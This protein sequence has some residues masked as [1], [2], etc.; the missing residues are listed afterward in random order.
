MSQNTLGTA[1]VVIVDGGE[2]LGL[3]AGIEA[4]FLSDLRKKR[5]LAIVARFETRQ[6]PA[7]ALD[8][9]KSDDDPLTER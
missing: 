4:E 7:L 2:L 3:L 6:D 1:L 9:S 5:S 8:V